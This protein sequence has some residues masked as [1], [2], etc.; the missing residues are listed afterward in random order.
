MDKPIRFQLYLRFS[1][2]MNCL[3]GSG[4]IKT[5]V[6]KALQCLS[7]IEIRKDL[8]DI[9]GYIFFNDFY[10]DYLELMTDCYGENWADDPGKIEHLYKEM[11]D[12]V[13]DLKIASKILLL[14]K[15]LAK[16][17]GNRQKLES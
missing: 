16:I 1:E 17:S 4:D 9:K 10:Q 15:R 3:I 7:T 14:Y 13:L 12:D 6:E 8:E 5:R 11:P 2:A